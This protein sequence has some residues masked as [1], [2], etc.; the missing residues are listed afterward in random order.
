MKDPSMKLLLKMGSTQICFQNGKKRP[1]QGFPPFLKTIQ[2]KSGKNRRFMKRNLMNP[3]PRSAGLPPGMSGSKKIR[4]LSC[5]PP[6]ARNVHTGSLST[7]GH[8]HRT[9]G[10]R[11]G[12]RIE[13]SSNEKKDIS[14]RRFFAE[15]H[16]ILR[17]IIFLMGADRSVS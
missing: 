4:P 14:R 11:T 16:E 1:S 17:E 15:K 9:Y 13:T 6:Y 8:Q 10:F 3:A 12:R 2:P 7:P 5:L